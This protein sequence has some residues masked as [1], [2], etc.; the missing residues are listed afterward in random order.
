MK[1]AKKMVIALV[2]VALGA[3]MFAG[4]GKV[5]DDPTTAT[6]ASTTDVTT[7][8]SPTDVEPEQPK[9][10][11]QKDI[12][13][14]KDAITDGLGEEA[15]AGF[16]LAN[17]S[18]TDEALMELIE[19]HGN[20][21]TLENELKP[22]ATFGYSNDVCPG[23]E[24]AEL[25][26][27]KL[28]V[29]VMD[30]SLADKVLDV[31]LAWNN[32]HPDDQIK[33]RGHVLVWHS[34]TPEWFFH[35][36]Y[37]TEK[38]LVKAEEMDKR[39]EWYIKT[40]LEYYVGEN[41]K[42]KDLFYGWDVVNEA[43]S[44]NSGTYRNSSEGSMW[45]KVY[46]DESFIINAFKYA[47]KY[48][49]AELE[50]Y[51][52]DY[53]ECVAKKQ[54]GIVNLLKAVK[55]EEG[56]PGVGTRID[57][58]GM[59]GH[60]DMYSPTA[61]Q[62]ES[63][64]RAYAE[65]VNN[66]QITELDIKAN[67]MYDGTEA[68]RE[69]VYKTMAYRYKEIFDTCKALKADGINISGITMWGVIDT[70]SWLN[71]QATVGGGTDGTQA[72]CP[73]LFD[74]DYQAKPAF[75]GFVDPTKLDPDTKKV[76]VIE[77]QDDTFAF[78]NTYE[79]TSENASYTFVPM[80]TADGLKVK[81]T[82]VDGT[83]DA[84]DAIEVYYD[85]DNSK[86]EAFEA[87]SVVV[88]RADAEATAD[89]YTA[90]VDVPMELFASLTIGFDVRVIDGNNILSFNDTK[91]TQETSSKF[92]AE[93]LMKPY[94]TIHRGTITVD[95]ELDEAWANAQD[96]PLYIVVGEVEVSCN[97]K[98]LWD[99]QCLYVYATVIDPDLNKV[100]SEVHQQDSIEVFIDENN[101]KA[102][103]YEEDDKQYRINFKNERSYNGSKCV[104]DNI[105]SAAKKTDNGYVVE[106]MFK[107]T[108]VRPSAGMEIGLELQVNDANSTGERIGTLSWFDTTGTGWTTPSVYGNAMLVD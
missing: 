29:P 51:Y 45:W 107:W 74:G 56:E 103:A 11:V 20:A 99:N 3:N 1:K 27:E 77:Y 6:V 53:N 88:K 47:N 34:Q 33:V 87:K 101:H 65:V 7:E 5:K 60:H 97:M 100:N 94:T 35:E 4:C 89:G 73:L 82:V 23:T 54:E 30:H 61:S 75:W 28:K 44:D 81:V 36:D 79:V 83:E 96:V 91:D 71:D 50:L 49:P 67:G 25:N 102:E 69:F 46:G 12:P 52:N 55:A 58:M 48:A 40:M 37:D 41:S 26:G 8:A 57:G 72:Q 85:F 43:I 10:E 62:I 59:Q 19:K 95:A 38:P 78:G 14:W 84:T 42:Y 18:L 98:L 90:I 63:A 105:E 64:A 9:V 21:I 22:D 80:W 16:C 15:I 68:T 24:E 104:R 108:D 76:T 31:I 92:Y 106:A 13:N 66:V 32:E 70:Y 17:T 39:Q 93:A 2:A 86:S